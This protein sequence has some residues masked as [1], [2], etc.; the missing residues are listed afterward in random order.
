MSTL[1]NL[2]RHLKEGQV[3]RRIDLTKWSKS[4]D[5]HLNMLVTDGTL[6]KMSPGVYYYPEKSVF[7]MTPAKDRDLVENFLKD[8]RFLL[9]SPNVYNNLGVG[10]TQLYNKTTVYNHKRHGNFK[11]GNREFTFQRK[12]FFPK[13]LT[14]EFLLVDLVNNVNALAED[15]NEV[16]ENVK[17]KARAMDANKLS[18]A[19]REYG[20]LRTKKFY[21]PILKVV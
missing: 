2:K 1:N 11:L 15:S 12:P 7:G 6:Q 8:D 10:T 9:T 21:N 13:K 4:I 17:R 20:S 19:V 16:L 18:K 14:P 5:R 3:Y